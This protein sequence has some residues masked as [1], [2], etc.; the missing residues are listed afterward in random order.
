MLIIVPDLLLKVSQILLVVLVSHH[1]SCFHDHYSH[2][3]IFVLTITGM[4]R[5]KRLKTCCL[6]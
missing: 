1:P 5:D 3:S 4:Q 6:E 2:N